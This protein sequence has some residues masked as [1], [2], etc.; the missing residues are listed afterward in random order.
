[1]SILLPPS[2]WLK[3][4]NISLMLVF[5]CSLPSDGGDHAGCGAHPVSVV[6]LGRGRWAGRGAASPPPQLNR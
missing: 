4:G 3:A 5:D 2:S 1:M 6:S